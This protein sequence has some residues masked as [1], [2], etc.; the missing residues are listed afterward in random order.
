[1]HIDIVV[2]WWTTSGLPF[3]VRYPRYEKPILSIFQ[4]A[5]YLIRALWRTVLQ[6]TV[7]V[8]RCYIRLIV[9]HWGSLNS[10]ISS[11][12]PSIALVLLSCPFGENQINITGQTMEG[13][14]IEMSVQP[15][16]RLSIWY[17]L[18]LEVLW[19]PH[20]LDVICFTIFD[21]ST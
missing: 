12:S 17:L 3:F 19:V 11:S 10:F 8:I 14:E 1:M 18:L 13:T 20:G 7:M 6:L 21:H 4:Y 5:L 15:N 9:W 2:S 16:W